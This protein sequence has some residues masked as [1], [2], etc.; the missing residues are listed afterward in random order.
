M[1]KAL[2]LVLALVLAL[3]MGVSAFAADLI[4]LN[5]VGSAAA[6]KTEIFVV[7]M[8]DDEYVLYTCPFE[9]ADLG[10][11]YVH[12]IALN[13]EI[14]YTDVKVTA[15]G[16]LDAEL[17]EYDP[18]TMTITGAMAD[19]TWSVTCKGEVVDC[20]ELQGLTYEEALEAAADLEKELKV[21]Y[22]GVACDVTVN[23]IKLTVENNFSAAF[24]EGTLKI[25]AKLGTKNYAKT[26]T[27]INDVTIFEYEMVKSAAKYYADGEALQLGDWGYSDFYTSE[28][29]YSYFFGADYNEWENRVWPFALVVS[30]TAFRAVEGKDLKLNVLDNDAAEISVTLK[31]I[32]KGQ[33]GVNFFAWADI[34]VDDRN[35][36]IIANNRLEAA[37]FGFMG[38]QVIKG[39][40]EIDVK[41][42]M[43]YYDLREAFGLKVEEEDIITYYVLKNGKAFD[44][45]T[46]D[47]MTDDVTANVELTIKGENEKLGW[48]TLALEVPAGEVSGEENPNTGAESVVGVVAAL[49]VVSVA[50]AAAVS[51]KK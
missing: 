8:A 40:F 38:D 35:D 25:E 51:L 10:K 29:G 12:Y 42:G 14:A 48:Y 32:A 9:L 3:S 44:E 13:P 43:N 11:D 49:A 46:V 30:T 27:L 37:S 18:E 36:D 1:K 28:Y 20:E 34:D 17:V 6:G 16:N 31:D 4:E 33:K 5:P 15:N 41:L 26:L 24:T 39:A 47:Y 7:D 19:P 23:V 2:A 50:T 21:T 45:F 22:Y